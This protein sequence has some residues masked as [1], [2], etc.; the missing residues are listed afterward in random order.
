MTLC[1]CGHPSIDHL[2]FD[3]GGEACQSLY[4]YCERYRKA[5]PE[6]RSLSAGVTPEGLAEEKVE[7]DD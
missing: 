1:V 5:A 3:A 7:Q 4:C 2:R 6:D